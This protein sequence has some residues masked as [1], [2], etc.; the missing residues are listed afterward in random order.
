MNN[1]LLTPAIILVSFGAAL[2]LSGWHAGLWRAAA[3][4]ERLNAAR[5]SI[6]A[7]VTVAVPSATARVA[8]TPRPKAPT[9]AP[10]EA[11]AQTVSQDV[12]PTVEAQAQAQAQESEGFLDARV[13]A[14][15]HG[16]RSH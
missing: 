3:A 7:P 10:P 15:E 2:G 12:E 16:A 8:D 14:A 9:V 6:P 13:R 5:I 1:R 11:P 4:N